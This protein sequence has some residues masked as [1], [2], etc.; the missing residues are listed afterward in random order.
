MSASNASSTTTCRS[1]FIG[2]GVLAIAVSCIAYADHQSPVTALSVSNTQGIA[3]GA[4]AA[5]AGGSVVIAPAGSRSATGSVVPISSNTGAAAQFTVSGDPEFTYSITLPADGTVTL[6]DGAGHSMNVN[7]FTSSPL[8]TGQLS[9][10]GSQQLAV[11]ATLNVGGNQPAGGY[12]GSFAV[13]V[14]YD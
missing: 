13:T 3:F 14:D 7:S 9:S 5:G 11:G 2:A 10:A 8:M 6:S 4:F 1:R 12:S